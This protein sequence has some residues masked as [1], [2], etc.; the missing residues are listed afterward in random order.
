M[1]VQTINTATLA[2]TPSTQASARSAPAT[3]QPNSPVAEQK[4]VTKPAVNQVQLQNA[5]TAAN[6]FVK[7]I[8]SAVEFSVDKD[9]GELV[10]KVMDITTKE[11]IRQIP[12]EEMLD[13][14]KALDKLQGLLIKQKA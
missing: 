6:E 11:V 8:N 5:V 10:V 14:A 2:A 12:T 13:I 1:D 7:P 3:V 9:S 4:Q